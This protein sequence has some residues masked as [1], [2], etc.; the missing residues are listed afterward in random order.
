MILLSVLIFGLA[1]CINSLIRNQRVSDFRLRII[2]MVFVSPI[3]R[4]K[5]QEVYER[6]SYEKMLY[7]FW[8]PLRL[9][10]F[11]TKEEIEILTSSRP[12]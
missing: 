11:Y 3:G 7:Q 5:R 1:F 4:E 6:V 9:R 8:K 12:Q 2:E 10:A